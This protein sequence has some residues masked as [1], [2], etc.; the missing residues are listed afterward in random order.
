MKCPT[1]RDDLEPR[2]AWRPLRNGGY[3]LGAF[4]SECG[5]W[6]KWIDQRSPLAMQAPPRPDDEK[7]LF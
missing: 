4:C 3:H 6:L 2:L 7:R 1:C 5:R